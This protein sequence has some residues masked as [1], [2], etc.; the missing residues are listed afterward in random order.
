MNI[1]KEIARKGRKKIESWGEFKRKAREKGWRRRLN[2]YI[3][4]FS[5]FYLVT[6]VFISL[7]QVAT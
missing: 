5:F 4:F 7:H 3:F 2:S 1:S 6:I